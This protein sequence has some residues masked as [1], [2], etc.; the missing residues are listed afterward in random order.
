MLSVRRKPLFAKM[1]NY[2]NPTPQERMQ[3]RLVAIEKEIIDYELLQR[4]YTAKL[5]A[6]KSQRRYLETALGLR[7]AA[8]AQARLS[9][10]GKNR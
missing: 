6:L 9:V 3:K 5:A 4:D 10:V 7:Q 2:L 1:P 8:N